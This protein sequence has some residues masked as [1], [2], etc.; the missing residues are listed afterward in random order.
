MCMQTI[1][2]NKLMIHVYNSLLFPYNWSYSKNYMCL[3]KPR[4]S[5][6]YYGVAA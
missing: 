5:V 6:F 3:T 2:G 4:A 1:I